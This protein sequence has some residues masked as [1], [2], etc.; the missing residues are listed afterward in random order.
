MTISIHTPVVT[1][2]GT[3]SSA[4]VALPQSAA[5][6]IR[7]VNG[8]TTNIVYVNAGGSSVTATTANFALAPFESRNLERDVNTDTYV[9]A[10]MDAGTAKIA[11]MPVAE[12]D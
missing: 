10:I 2:A 4:N 11:F 5:K 3:T 12:A 1:I 9:A 6:Y 7:V 8:S